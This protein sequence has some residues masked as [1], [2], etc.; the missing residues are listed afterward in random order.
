MSLK[1]AL[2]SS[3]PLPIYLCLFNDYIATSAGLNKSLTFCLLPSVFSCRMCRPLGEAA[4][5]L[6][7]TAW[8]TPT[9]CFC[10]R[11]GPLQAREPPAAGRGPL[12]P[13]HPE[14]AVC[15]ARLRGGRVP[16]GLSEV[17]ARVLRA[18]SAPPCPAP[19][20]GKTSSCPALWIIVRPLWCQML[21]KILFDW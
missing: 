18:R 15:G 10:G 5:D 8:N 11:N 3:L 4:G 9:W 19:P 20:P 17:S 12:H 6:P 2:L 7:L 16:V 21:V 13:Q 1:I 14:V